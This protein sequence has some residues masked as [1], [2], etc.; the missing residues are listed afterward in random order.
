MWAPDRRRPGLWRADAHTQSY[1]CL[2]GQCT[3][4][5]ELI[6]AAQQEG[7]ELVRGQ[8]RRHEV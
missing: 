3:G 1:T 2:C 7:Q 8:Q 5:A 6:T 4:R